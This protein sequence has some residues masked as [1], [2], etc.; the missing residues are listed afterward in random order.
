MGSDTVKTWYSLPMPRSAVPLLFLCLSASSALAKPSP[1]PPAGNRPPELELPPY[2]RVAPG[3]E[4]SFGLHVVDQD[5]DTVRVDLVEKP[6]SAQYDPITLTVR[7]KPTPRDLP[8]GRFKVRITETQ[9]LGGG[10]RVFLHAFGIAVDRQARDL[11]AP[12]PLGTAVELLITI[13]DPERLAQVNKD[14]PILKMFEVLGRVEAARR[15]PKGATPPDPKLLYRDAILAIGLRHQ[16]KRAEWS[17]KEFELSAWKITAVRPRM[18]KKMQELRVVYENVRVPEPMYLMF[19][20]RLVKDDPDLSA[21]AKALNNKEFARLVHE[22]FFVGADLNPK[23]LTDKKAHGKAVSAFVSRILDYK[24]DKPDMG[25]EFMALPHEAR[26]GGGSARAKDGSYESGD[27]WAWAVLKGKWDQGKLSIVS[28]PIPGFTSDVRPSADGASWQT[29][30][31]SKFDPDDKRHAAGYEVLCRKKLGFTDLPQKG[32]GGKIAPSPVDATNLFVD[33]KMGDLVATVPL[34]D[35]RRDNFEE[36]G[37]TCSQCHIRDF[38]NGDL[39]DRG[40]RD[41]KAGGPKVA[42]PP[43]PTTFFNIVP[44]ESWRPFTVEFMRFQ[45]CLFKDA[46]KKHLGQETSLACPLVAE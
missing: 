2:H 16:N 30:C 35:P 4:I 34:R 21:E 28:I 40:V 23:F 11:P 18:D 14:W 42:S 22:A 46:F 41:P 31:A 6:S 29:V 39:R 37:M 33:F 20:W 10:R 19:R 8:E 36:N 17:S 5:G 9:R 1:E 25:T 24:S 13:H 26:F 32:E 15:G 45:E 44:E 12:Q 7:W 43:I 27:G 3:R 38:A